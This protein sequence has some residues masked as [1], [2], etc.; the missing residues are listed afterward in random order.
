MLSFAFFAVMINDVD[1]YLSPAISR[2]LFVDDLSVW[3]SALSTWSAERQLQV[4]VTQLE[5]WSSVNGLRF[6]TAKTAAMHFLSAAP[7]MPG[8]IRLTAWGA[9]SRAI[10]G[11]ISQGAFGQSL[12]VQTTH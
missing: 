11:Q 10:R 9:P 6:S 2:A 7:T 4:A 12:D 8:Y 5:K 1:Q 3:A